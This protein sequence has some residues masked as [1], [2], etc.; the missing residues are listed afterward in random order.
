[1]DGS[2]L[3]GLPVR[4][5]RPPAPDGAAAL[6]RVA[7]F[8]GALLAGALLVVLVGGAAFA[9]ELPVALLGAFLAGVAFF[10]EGTFFADAFFA[11]GAA[12]DFVAFAPAVFDPVAFALVEFRTGAAFLPGAAFFAGV[13]AFDG[14]GF[15]T[16]AFFTAAVFAA[17]LVLGAAFLPAPTGRLTVL[18]AVFAAFG[19]AAVFDVTLARSAMASPT[20]KTGARR[21]A[22]HSRGW[23]EYGTYGR[24][25]NTPHPRSPI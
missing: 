21:G 15:V 9:L 24:P 23:Q 1:V 20:C 2:L 10:V 13:A 25:T 12:F 4:V 14:T 6:V 17:A 11:A 8:A 3:G 16:V 22:A 7:V 18:S 5:V 19:A